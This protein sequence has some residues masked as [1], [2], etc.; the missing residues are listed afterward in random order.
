MSTRPQRVRKP[1]CYD[2]IEDVCFEMAIDGEA[3]GEEEGSAEVAATVFK[4]LSRKRTHME[5]TF[6]Q[7]SASREPSTASG[8]ASPTRCS[9]PQARRQRQAQA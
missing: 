3:S 6:Q 8:K 2:E 4:T 5:K 9:G 1:V 7:R